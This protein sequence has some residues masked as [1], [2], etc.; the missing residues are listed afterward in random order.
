MS[1]DRVDYAVQQC[2]EKMYRTALQNTY[3]ALDGRRLFDC[4]DPRAKQYRYSASLGNMDYYV[5]IK[6]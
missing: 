6:A 2:P 4:L 1:D 5:R 3:Y